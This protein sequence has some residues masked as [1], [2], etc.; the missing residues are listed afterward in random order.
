MKKMKI[1]ITKANILPLIGFPLLFIAIFTIIIIFWEPLFHI[2]RNKEVMKKWLSSQ[3]IAAPLL[4]I[5]LQILQVIIFIIPGEIPQVAGGYLFGTW[6]G[7]LYS[8]LGIAIG[9]GINFFLARILGIPFVKLILKKE[10]F[11]KIAGLA[12]SSK[13]QIIIFSIFLIPGLPIKDI[14]TY[15]V[16]LSPMKFY[17]FLV[18]SMLGRLPGIIGSAVMGSA[19]ADQNWV[20]AAVVFGA[21]VILFFTGYFLKERILRMIR[22]K[23]DNI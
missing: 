18:V 2:F 11:E 12:S 23:S 10:Q 17:V 9:S 20:L 14:M 21:A 16:G 4:F 13:S 19:A 3:G 22:Q 15:V 6:Y 1:K 5:G 8:I 7:V